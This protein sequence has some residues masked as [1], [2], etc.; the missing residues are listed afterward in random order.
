MVLQGL[1]YVLCIC[2]WN[3]FC[4]SFPCQEEMRWCALSTHAIPFSQPANTPFE[5]AC[6]IYDHHKA[7]SKDSVNF[8][9]GRDTWWQDAVLTQSTTCPVEWMEAEAPLFKLYTSGS[10]GDPR[11]RQIRH[12]NTSVLVWISVWIKAKSPS[13]HTLLC[14]KQ[15][16]ENAGGDSYLDHS[17]PAE[18][19]EDSFLD[20]CCFCIVCRKT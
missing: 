14:L 16:M 1:S 20:V 3:S 8:K 4:V 11:S 7:F 10:T 15:K 18:V 17:E 2:I 5:Q 13:S 12:S 19:E 6:L 9:T